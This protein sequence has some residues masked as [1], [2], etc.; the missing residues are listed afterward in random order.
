MEE[1]ID[2]PK[3]FVDMLRLVGDG[4]AEA[5]LSRELYDLMA[6]LREQATATMSE[7]KGEVILKVKI[8]VDKSAQNMTVNYEVATKEPKPPRQG[9]IFFIDSSGNWCR[10]NQR[11]QDLP[12]RAVP[13]GARTNNVVDPAAV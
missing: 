5:C 11:Q 13:S 9:S 1:R 8:E 6:E 4:E 2:G 10:N 7:R 3:S 12:L